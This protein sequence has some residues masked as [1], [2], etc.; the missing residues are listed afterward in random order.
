MFGV[1]V[2]LCKHPA[3]ARALSPRILFE[4]FLPF[5]RFPSWILTC[6][7][8]L[9]QGNSLRASRCATCTSGG[10]GARSASAAHSAR[11]SLPT[12]SRSATTSAPTPGRNRTIVNTVAGCL[13]R[14]TRWVSYHWSRHSLVIGKKD[15]ADCQEKFNVFFTALCKCAC[16]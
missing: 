13:H 14:S 8:L 10:S 3:S 1:L 9:W 16:P 7:L 11:K 12:A 15:L 2:A 5:S 6:F 4:L